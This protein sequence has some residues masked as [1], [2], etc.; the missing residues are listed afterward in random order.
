[1]S[2]C[3]PLRR[4]PQRLGSSLQCH[5][6]ARLQPSP[7]SLQASSLPPSLPS[8]EITAKGGT[9]PPALTSRGGGKRR[10]GGPSPCRRLACGGASAARFLLHLCEELRAALPGA[11]L[12]CAGKLQSRFSAARLC[13]GTVCGA[14]PSQPHALLP[15]RRSRLLLCLHDPLPLAVGSSPS[16]G[17]PGSLAGA[18]GEARC[19]SP[20]PPGAPAAFSDLRS[21]KPLYRIIFFLNFCPR[22]CLWKVKNN[23]R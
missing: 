4:P 17:P 9:S 2:Y 19:S 8:P 15:A 16:P 11:W 23:L 5:I 20:A 18:L 7:N 22:N 21:K 1:M 13:C 3:A 12:R 14:D 10:P 6:A